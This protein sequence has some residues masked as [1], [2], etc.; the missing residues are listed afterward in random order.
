MIVNHDVQIPLIA[1][2]LTLFIIFFKRGKQFVLKI[3]RTFFIILYFYELIFADLSGQLCRSKIHMA[4]FQWPFAAL[5][6]LN[7]YLPFKKRKIAV[8]RFGI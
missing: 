5:Y 7:V 6:W 1:R 3:R 4:L 8:S 2:F